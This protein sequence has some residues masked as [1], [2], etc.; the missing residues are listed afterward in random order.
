[1]SSCDATHYGICPGMPL[2]EAQALLTSATFLPH[3]PDADLMELQ[4]LACVC[5]QYS[6]VV[7]LELSHNAHCLVLDVTGCTHLFDGEPGTACQ[8]V[9]DLAERGYF[10][11]VATANTIGAAWAIARYG[12]RAGSDRRLRSL[13]VEALR[14]PNKLVARLHE[15]DLRTVGQLPALPRDTLPSRFGTELTKRLDQMFGRCT[16]LLVPV[17]RSEPVSA[18][19][20]TEEPVCHREAVLHICDELLAQVLSTVRARGEGILRLTLHLNNEA[21]D[22]PVSFEVGLMQPG[23]SPVHV[24]GLLRLKLEA[25]A[26]PEWLYEITMKASV[27]APLQIRQRGLFDH[28][29]PPDDSSVRRLMDRLTARLGRDAVV[30]ARLLPEAVP[31]QSVRYEPLTDPVSDAQPAGGSAIASARPLELFPKPLP[32]RVMSIVPDGPP[33]RFHWNRR[34]Y[35]VAHCTEPERIATGW[36]QDT[37]AIHRDYYQV[38]T[39]S[40]ARFWLFR[41]GN[42]EWF[43]HGVFE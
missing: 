31:E 42:R 8:V 29:E 43:L 23:D 34:E 6:P 30:R 20:S 24:M 14:I 2:A 5:H 26:I 22:P 16:E 15:F 1:M 36:W 27:T 18:Q 13:P 11:H 7:G 35:R 25:V 19:W 21:A 37:G 3:D 32:V 9:G 4:T 38:E 10:A 33:V 17:P 41:D 39:Q 28:H 40:G 12:H